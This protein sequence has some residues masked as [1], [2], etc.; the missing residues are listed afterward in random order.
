MYQFLFYDTKWKEYSSHPK[1]FRPHSNINAN[2][3]GSWFFPFT[4][5]LEILVATSLQN[6]SPSPP[7]D[8]E[9]I[10]DQCSAFYSA[11]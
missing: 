6:T 8:S 1:K 11:R 10:M 7:L 4:K 9:L 2:R 3:F 5:D